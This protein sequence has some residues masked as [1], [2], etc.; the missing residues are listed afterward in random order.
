MDTTKLVLAA[1]AVVVV[2][3]ALSQAVST[4]HG[5]FN[6]ASAVFDAALN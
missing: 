4:G 3:L 2:A 6:E 1:T 5:A